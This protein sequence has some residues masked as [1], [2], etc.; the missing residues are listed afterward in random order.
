V[1]RAGLAALLVAAGVLHFVIP[2]SYQRIV[3]RFLGHAPLLVAVS[4]VAELAAGAL[5]AVPRTRRLGAGLAFVLFLVV[6]P[7]NIQMALD[8]GLPDAGFP[9]G[10]AL[11]AWLRVPLQVP[12][13]VWAWREA[14]A[15][16]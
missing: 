11:V 12:L 1:S 16:R 14:R 6:W 10:S 2:R 4:G 8:G 13:L 5:V 15:A 3:P 9:A 7:A